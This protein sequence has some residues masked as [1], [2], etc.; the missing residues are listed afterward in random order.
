MSIIGVVSMKGGVGKTSVTANLAAAMA[1]TLGPAQL[2]VFDDRLV[3]LVGHHDRL[4]EPDGEEKLDRRR[5]I[6][7]NGPHGLE[8]HRGVRR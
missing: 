2:A 8:Q 5:R 4:G 6:V 3:V 7:A 1:A